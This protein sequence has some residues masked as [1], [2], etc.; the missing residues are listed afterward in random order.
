MSGTMQSIDQIQQLRSEIS[1]TNQA[2]RAL[3]SLTVDGKVQLR[4]FLAIVRLLSGG[5]DSL[6]GLVANLQVT[7]ATITAVRTATKAMQ[8][9]LGPVGWLLLGAGTLAGLTTYSVYSTQTGSSVVR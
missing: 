9:E 7:L 8:I 1:E 4:D 5:N 3:T 2:M 6:D